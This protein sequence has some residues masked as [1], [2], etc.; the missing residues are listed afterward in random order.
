[1]CPSGQITHWMSFSP[2]FDQSL[3]SLLATYCPS[4][5]VDCSSNSRA[6]SSSI[7]SF[8]AIR[9]SLLS[10][11]PRN[12]DGTDPSFRHSRLELSV[13]RRSVSEFDVTFFLFVFIFVPHQ[14]V[15]SYR[16]HSRPSD[17]YSSVLASSGKYH[18]NPPF[19]FPLPY[20]H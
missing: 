6:L 15:V 11:S 17:A 1:M 5:E 20:V 10:L 9:K 18:S 2:I 4:M 13:V 8:I 16:I 7:N 14:M 19:A 3:L 12:G